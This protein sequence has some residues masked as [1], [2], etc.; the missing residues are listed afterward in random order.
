MADPAKNAATPVGLSSAAPGYRR[1][2]G[3]GIASFVVAILTIILLALEVMLFTDPLGVLYAD[4]LIAGLAAT[5]FVLCIF[6]TALTALAGTILGIIGLCQPDR[7]KLFAV[8]GLS[9]CALFLLVF[10]A[11]VVLGL[12][13]TPAALS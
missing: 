1:H 3:A 9:V 11:L 6:V 4:Y 8:L 13:L 10:V 5:A 2:A 7:K 12:A